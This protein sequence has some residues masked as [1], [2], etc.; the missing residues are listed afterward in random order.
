MG[1]R[2]G[3]ESGTRPGGDLGGRVGRLQVAGKPVGDAAEQL[4]RPVL[5]LLA[6]VRQ[7][8]RL[9]AIAAQQLVEFTRPRARVHLGQDPR[10]V[11]P[12]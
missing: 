4:Q 10:L 7:M 9:Q 12:L 11:L 2:A 6:P 1:W 8:R 3:D 5:A